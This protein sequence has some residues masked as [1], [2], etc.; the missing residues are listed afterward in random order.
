MIQR[1]LGKKKAQ[2]QEDWHPP[3]HEAAHAPADDESNWLVSYA[4]MMT[5][6]CGFF[7]M[8]FSMSKLDEPQYEKVKEAVAKQFGGDYKSPTKEFARFVS[9]V[10]TDAGVEKDVAVK[11]DPSGVSLTFESTILF[12][13]LSSE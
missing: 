2:P 12:D 7:I 6:L 11:Y 8:M 4:D 10:L 3:Q 13:T 5:L 1:V 9:Q